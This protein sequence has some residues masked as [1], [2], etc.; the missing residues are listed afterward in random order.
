MED[1]VKLKNQG[2]TDMEAGVCVCMC[3]FAYVCVRERDVERV[4]GSAVQNQ[5]A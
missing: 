2:N 4:A 1:S 5:I 3:M